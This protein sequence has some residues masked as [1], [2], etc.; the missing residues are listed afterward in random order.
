MRQRL[1][2]SARAGLG[3]D[4]FY[5]CKKA[6]RG[7]IAHRD[8]VGNVREHGQV[9]VAVSKGIRVRQIQIIVIQHILDACCLEYP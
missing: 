3:S 2:D 8:T 6:L 1:P 7:C 9:V 4:I 5:L